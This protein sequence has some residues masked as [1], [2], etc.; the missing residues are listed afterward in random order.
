MD[1]K[2]RNKILRVEEEVQEICQEFNPIAAYIGKVN[3]LAAKERIEYCIEI[4]KREDFPNRYSILNHTTLSIPPSEYKDDFSFQLNFTPSSACISPYL[5]KPT[6][7][8]SLDLF[9]SHVKL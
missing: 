9:L 1:N 7:A 2:L 3:F 5:S 6:T 4:G 8:E